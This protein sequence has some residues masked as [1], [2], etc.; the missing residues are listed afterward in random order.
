MSD[1]Y[2]TLTQMG[3]T[4]PEEISRY[5]MQKTD[6]N[7][8]VLRI[9]YKRAKGSLLPSSKKFKFPRSMKVIEQDGGNRKSETITEIS[10][11]LSKAIME[12]H[13]I[14]NNKHSREEQKEII[15]DEIQRLEE[16]MKTRI[17]YLKSLI[18]NL[19]D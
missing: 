9:V 8:D 4:N 19:E 18:S 15:A 2:P 3:I 7:F 1:K 10:P 11:T 12:L 14:V 17:T 6:Y 13:K 16:E 5:S